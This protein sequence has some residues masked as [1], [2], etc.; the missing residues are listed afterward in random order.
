MA[1][2][3]RGNRS[4]FYRK[5][6]INGK[7]KSEYVGSGEVAALLD[8]CEK[9]RRELKELEKENQK[10]ERMRGEIIDDEINALSEINQSLVE[11]LFLINGFH[12]HKR[13]W[14]KKRK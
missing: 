8:R 7:V 3:T 14:R 13:Q 11:A 1:W 10:R 5:E 6:R 9:G 12:R 2:E 4:Y